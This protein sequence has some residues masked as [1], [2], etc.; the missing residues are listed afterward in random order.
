MQLRVQLRGCGLVEARDGGG[1][2]SNLVV[3]LRL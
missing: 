2:A 3:V 1:A